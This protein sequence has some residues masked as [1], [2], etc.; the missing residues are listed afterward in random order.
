MCWPQAAFCWQVPISAH[1]PASAFSLS[2][3]WF[4]KGRVRQRE[5]KNMERKVMLMSNVRDWEEQRVAHH[6]VR[7]TAFG[8]LPRAL[9][10]PDPTVMVSKA[11]ASQIELPGRSCQ[12][13]SVLSTGHACWARQTFCLCQQAPSECCRLSHI[14]RMTFLSS[15]CTIQWMQWHELYHCTWKTNASRAVLF[16]PHLSL[17]KGCQSQRMDQAPLIPNLDTALI[18]LHNRCNCDFFP[19]LLAFIYCTDYS[20]RECPPAPVWCELPNCAHKRE[21]KEP[22]VCGCYRATSLRQKTGGWPWESSFHETLWKGM[23]AK[24]LHHLAAQVLFVARRVLCRFLAGSSSHCKPVHVLGG[25]HFQSERDGAKSV[26]V[27]LCRDY[28]CCLLAN[29]DTRCRYPMPQRGPL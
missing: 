19:G 24:H 5:R 2:A 8:I 23:A 3:P 26:S 25:R 13:L 28:N 14:Q 7:G 6:R 16:P 27:C 4:W 10:R 29:A 21:R 17:L 20:A 15:L 1:L 22:F 11:A 12:P 9:G 18:L